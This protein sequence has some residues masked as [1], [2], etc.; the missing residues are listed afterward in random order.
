MKFEL[1]LFRF[2]TYIL[3]GKGALLFSKIRSLQLSRYT[4]TSVFNVMQ[5]R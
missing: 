5:Q 4:E 2:P 1:K 3:Y